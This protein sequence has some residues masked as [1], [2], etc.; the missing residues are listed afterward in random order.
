MNGEIRSTT[1]VSGQYLQVPVERPPFAASWANGE[2][3]VGVDF[4][5]SMHVRVL[6]GSFMHECAVVRDLVSLE[7]EPCYRVEIRAARV[8]LEVSQSSLEN[9]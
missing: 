5:P 8:S 3:I 2:K 4:A 1:R 7:P 9:I 6:G